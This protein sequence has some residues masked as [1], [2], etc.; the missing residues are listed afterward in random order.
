M[1]HQLTKVIVDHYPVLIVEFDDGIAGKV[2][3]T[4]DIANKPMFVELRNPALFNKVS[5]GRNGDCLG[6]K[7]DEVGNEIDLSADGLRNAI[8]IQLVKTRAAQHRASRQAAE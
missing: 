4:N 8:E 5:I 3:M 2:D 6:W 1:R 7:L